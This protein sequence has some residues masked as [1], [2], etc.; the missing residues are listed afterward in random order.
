[1]DRHSGGYVHPSGNKN[2]PL[3]G[4]ITPSRFWYKCGFK[5]DIISCFSYRKQFSEVSKVKTFGVNFHEKKPLS[6][7]LKTQA[8]GSFDCKLYL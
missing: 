3:I 8:N 2:H 6:A 5:I 7:V 1:M 4:C